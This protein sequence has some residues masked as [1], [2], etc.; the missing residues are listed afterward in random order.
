[1]DLYV[2]VNN[3]LWIVINNNE[4]TLRRPDV[5]LVS[6]WKFD[7]LDGLH[8]PMEFLKTNEIKNGN[9]TWQPHWRWNSG[10]EQEYGINNF[11][12]LSFKKA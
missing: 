2:K 11:K 4:I 6:G 8:N 10:L 5:N 9:S 7:I 3:D 12:M 1:M